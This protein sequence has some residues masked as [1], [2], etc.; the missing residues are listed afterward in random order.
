MPLDTQCQSPTL[1]SLPLPVDSHPWAWLSRAVSH[2]LLCLC[3]TLHDLTSQRECPIAGHMS[4]IQRG[5]QMGVQSMERKSL[6]SSDTGLG[7]KALPINKS[8]KGGPPPPFLEGD[9]LLSSWKQMI[10]NK[11]KS[12][13][14]GKSR[15]GVLPRCL[16]SPLSAISTLSSACSLSCLLSSPSL[17][18]AGGN[19][20]SKDS[21]VK[22]FSYSS[23]CFSYCPI[24]PG[25]LER[26]IS[27]IRIKSDC[28]FFF[29][30]I[31]LT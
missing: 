13:T 31:K 2:L 12:M 4:E 20:C 22:W 30:G 27:P 17:P 24:H 11:R 25:T 8:Y 29:I 18:H 23:V 28:L 1:C 3:V 7:R 15:K 5:W 16:P 6:A 26:L 19:R 21:K 10:K 9:R 14:S